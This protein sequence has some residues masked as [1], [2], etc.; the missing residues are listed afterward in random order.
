[1]IFLLGDLEFDCIGFRLE[2]VLYSM[3]LKD[4]FC[5]Y[6]KI[7]CLMQFSDTISCFY[8]RVPLNL[9]GGFGY[10]YACTTVLLTIC[11]LF[12]V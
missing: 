5:C 9:S 7:W 12:E 11:L 4:H 6:L 8:K 3:E 1:M 2:S 10:S